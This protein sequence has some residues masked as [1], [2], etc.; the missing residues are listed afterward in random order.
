MADGEIV[1]PSIEWLESYKPSVTVLLSV[2]NSE[3]YVGIAIQSILDQTFRDFELIAVDD[4]SVDRSWEIVKKYADQDV[5]IKAVRNLVNLGGCL[6]LNVGL[7]LARGKYIARLD[8]DDWFFPDRLEKQFKFLEEHPDIGLVG[9]G[10]EMMNPAGEVY[11]KRVYSLS[12]DEIRKKIFF[13][14]PF[15]HPLVMMRKAVL[16]K[17]GYYDPIYAPADDYELYFRIGC[18]SKFANLDAILMR[19][20][21]LAT[22]ITIRNTKKM[23]LATVR[24]RKLYSKNSN[25]HF[26]MIA[27]TYN[28]LH[29][30]SIFIVPPRMKLSLYNFFRNE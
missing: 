26:G 25:Y 7:K 15:A 24:V 5:R 22:S 14:S 9:G 1:K 4:C 10:M 23:E 16:D 19:Y 27:K 20:R 29:Y 28:F 30:L 21:V 8:N 13:C 17:V 18:E 12:D 11:G 6:T 3:K 2:Y